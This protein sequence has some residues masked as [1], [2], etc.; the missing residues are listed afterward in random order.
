MEYGT[1]S[2]N[3]PRLD[4]DRLDDVKQQLRDKFCMKGLGQTKQI[5]GLRVIRTEKKI[6]Y[7]F[8]FGFIFTIASYAKYQNTSLSTY[9]L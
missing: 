9:R 6:V 7:K 1:S 2:W 8:E 4:Q 5:L 3:R